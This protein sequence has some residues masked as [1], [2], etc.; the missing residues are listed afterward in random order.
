MAE[1]EKDIRF[2]SRTRLTTD[3]FRQLQAIRA[4]TFES[5]SKDYDFS[6][7]TMLDHWA[8]GRGYVSQTFSR[9]AWKARGASPSGLRI[10]D[11]G[12]GSK[13]I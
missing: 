6:R 7:L 9:K 5:H 3:R 4:E 8:A 10:F 2:S 13:E 12:I 1:R 11:P